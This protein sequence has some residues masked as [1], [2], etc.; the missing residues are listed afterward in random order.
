MPELDLF[1]RVNFV[2]VFTDIK[3]LFA[4]IT[5]HQFNR[6]PLPFAV[7]RMNNSFLLCLKFTILFPQNVRDS[8]SLLLWIPG[9]C[10]CKDVSIYYTY[11]LSWHQSSRQFK[12][13]SPWQDLLP[14]LGNAL[15]RGKKSCLYVSD[16][17][18]RY[19]AIFPNNERSKLLKMLE[20]NNSWKANVFYELVSFK[21]L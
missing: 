18:I 14:V 4:D 10:N 21:W 13:I 2:Q 5:E 9:F 16:Q 17:N 3:T 15:W 12:A 8:S 11:W 20:K 7:N 6:W 19:I 1:S